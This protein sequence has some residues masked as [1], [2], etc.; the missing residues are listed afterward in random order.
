M[1]RIAQV[2]R[3]EMAVIA[4]LFRGWDET[5][6]WSCLQGYMGD[7]WLDDPD[8]PRSAQIIVGD[9]CFFAGVPHEELALHIPADFSSKTILFIPQHEGWEML[10]ERLYPHAERFSRYALQKDRD[11]FHPETLAGYAASLPAG[12]TLRAIDE[13]LYHLT[14]L[15]EWSQDLCSQFP[16]YDAY[17]ERGMGFAVMRESELVCGASSYTVYKDGIEI[18]IDTKESYRRQGLALACAARLILACLECGLYPSWDA[19]NIVSL[20]L[21]EKLG[22]RPA[23]E[24]AAYEVDISE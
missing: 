11:A 19:A 23:G 16:T 7:A 5:M 24:Y 6:I 9:F 20:H 18:E 3:D 8:Y 22:Y 21:A 10:I 1:R 15:E 13:E 2:S 17:K 14:A 4:H 12:F